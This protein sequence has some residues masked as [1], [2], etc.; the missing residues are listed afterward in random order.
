MPRR[1]RCAKQHSTVRLNDTPDSQGPQG[2]RSA[3]MA[4][5]FSAPQLLN[6]AIREEHTGAAFYKA[7]AHQTDSP[8]LREFALKVAQME[9]EHE[10][11][12]KA[13]LTSFSSAQRVLPGL[14]DRG[15]HL[16]SWT[17]RRRVG[18]PT[19]FGRASGRDGNGD[20]KEH[21][22]A[23]PGDDAL[24]S[25]AT[26]RGARRRRRRRKTA[27]GGFRE[28]QRGALFMSCRWLP[29]VSCIFLSLPQ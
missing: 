21:A 22:V 24:C 18:R 17:G 6:V 13:L 27:P 7:L 20:G 11:E 15:P 29:T 10:R 12:F 25:R 28:I 16:P 14:L 9:E 19:D 4:C 8:E 5:L 3:G 26:T 2:T 23:L 1:S